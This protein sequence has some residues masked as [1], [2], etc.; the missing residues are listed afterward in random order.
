[1]TIGKALFRL[2]ADGVRRPPQSRATCSPYALAVRHRTG[3]GH[4]T[5]RD[6]LPAPRID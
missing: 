1:M 3:T 2:V 6:A 5:D 4:P